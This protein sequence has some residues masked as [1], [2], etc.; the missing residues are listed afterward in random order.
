MYQRG[1]ESGRDD[2]GASL[3]EYALL[4]ALVLVVCVVAV[5][6]FGTATGDSLSRADGSLFADG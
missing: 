1:S 2:A 4:V 3:V 5:G 6:F